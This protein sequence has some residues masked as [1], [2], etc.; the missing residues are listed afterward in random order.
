M[1]TV[2]RV[3]QIFGVIFILIALVGFFSGM[4]M[5][6]ALLLGLFPVNLLHNVVHLI[7]GIW[8]LLAART[9]SGAKTY[10]QVGG[11]IYLLLAVLG[12]VDPTGFGIVPLGGNDIWLHAAIGIVLA[13]VGFTAKDTTAPAPAT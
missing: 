3:A 13:A 5:E 11:V 4:S 6:P 10:A 8:G 1:T 9:F 12:F 7:F 2:Q